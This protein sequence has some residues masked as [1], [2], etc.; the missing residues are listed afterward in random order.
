MLPLG[1]YK[2]PGTNSFVTSLPIDFALN[3]VT[4]EN[5]SSTGSLH[6][7][8][9][10]PLYHQTLPFPTLGTLPSI[11]I[12]RGVGGRVTFDFLVTRT[13]DIKP[14]LSFSPSGISKCTSCAMGSSYSRPREVERSCLLTYKKHLM[15]LLYKQRNPFNYTGRHKLA[16]KL[17]YSLIQMLSFTQAYNIL[18]Y[19][20]VTRVEDVIPMCLRFVYSVSTH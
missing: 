9:S 10:H 14:A 12:L 1:K 6:A 20:Q 3:Y 11:Y 15:K 19:K 7:T 13:K 4:D 5:E 18:L 16:N 2:Y 8:P 17:V